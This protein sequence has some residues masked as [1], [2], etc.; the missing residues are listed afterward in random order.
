VWACIDRIGEIDPLLNV[1]AV[2]RFNTAVEEAQKVDRIL[3]S[4]GPVARKQLENSLPFMG[5]PFRYF[6]AHHV[7]YQII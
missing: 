5:V 2:E 3:N 4:L 1:V 6:L 7:S